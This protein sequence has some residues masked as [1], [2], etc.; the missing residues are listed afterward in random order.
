M[1]R[2]EIELNQ[3][4]RVVPPHLNPATMKRDVDPNAI[5]IGSKEALEYVS[6]LVNPNRLFDVALTTYN[7][8][9]VTLVA[10]QT[11]KDPKEYVPYLRELKE[12][13]SEAYMKFR[14]HLDLKN[15]SKALKKLSRSEDDSH[16]EEALQLIRKQR[17]FKVALDFYAD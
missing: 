8:D 16:F 4:A 2:T 3:T 13:A 6:W 9:L 17:L 7:F 12:Y 15:Y 5:K 1:R 10:T 14:V 11:Q